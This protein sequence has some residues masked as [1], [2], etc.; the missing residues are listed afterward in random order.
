MAHSHLVR[1][2]NAVGRLASV[3]APIL[4]R[5]RPSLLVAGRPT[6]DRVST[7]SL[8]DLVPLFCHVALRHPLGIPGLFRSRGLP[9]VLLVVTTVGALPS[10]RSAVRGGVDVDMRHTRLLCRWGNLN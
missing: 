10:G 5:D 6:L 9:D 4:S 2:G 7:G 3:R 1:A 8:D